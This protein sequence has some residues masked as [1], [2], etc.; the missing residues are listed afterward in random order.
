MNEI[1]VNP[2]QILSFFGNGRSVL[3]TVVG[4]GF[5][6]FRHPVGLFSFFDRGSGFIGRIHEFVRQLHRHGFAIS[7]AGVIGQPAH[8]K[9]GAPVAPHFH[10]DLVGGSPHPAGFHFHQG[11]GVAYRFFQGFNGVVAGALLDGTQSLINQAVGQIFFAGLEHVGHQN[12]HQAAVV[13][14]VGSHGAAFD[15]ATTGHRVTKGDECTYFFLAPPLPAG[16]AG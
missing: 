8:G 16:A 4:K 14:G 5:V 9:G 11:R 2:L 13:L 1:I 15:S 3:V 7:L 6:G 10:G 12:I